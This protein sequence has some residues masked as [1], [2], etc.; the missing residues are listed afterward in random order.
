MARG[1][2]TRRVPKCPNKFS[3][4]GRRWAVCPSTRFRGSHPGAKTKRAPGA[5]EYHILV[6]PNVTFT[7]NPPQ[8]ERR[9]NSQMTRP[10]SP[11]FPHSSFGPACY[12]AQ[13]TGTHRLRH[14]LG[15]STIAHYLPHHD[16]QSCRLHEAQR[17]T[18]SR[19]VR[20]QADWNTQQR[21][22][23]PTH[24]FLHNATPHANT[25]G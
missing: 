25:H 4:T 3:T 11:A 8:R 24:G 5:G 14:G 16:L 6:N 21:N 22:N 19:E 15:G 17:Q 23:Y 12:L 18:G 7:V 20:S 13:Q 9:G 2:S 10:P 1:F